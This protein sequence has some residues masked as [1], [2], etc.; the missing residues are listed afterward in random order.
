[1]SDRKETNTERVCVHCGDPCGS[2]SIEVD[3]KPFCCAG[4]KTVYF[5]LHDHDLQQYYQLEQQPGLKPRLEAYANRFAYLDDPAV[6][7]KLLDF[8]DGRT[9]RVRL[10]IPQ[11]HCS[12][13]IWLLENLYILDK[14]IRSSRVDFPNKRVAV[15]FSREE[16]S[17]RRL[18]EL[19][20]SLGYEP[21]I[22]LADLDSKPVDGAVRGLYARLAVAGFCFGNVMLLSFP[23]YLGLDDT[24]HRL[25]GNWFNYLNAL[26][27]T[28][29]IF[30]SASGYFVSAWRGLRKRFVNMDLPI[31]LGIAVL[32]IRSLYDI[33]IL[34]QAGYM[35]S[36][37]G[38]VF[39]LLIGRLYQ[40]KT[41]SA[42]AFDR[43]YRS[44]L[45]IA[46]LRKQDN[47][48]ATVPINHLSP[49]DRIIIRNLELIPADS[50]LISGEGRL[51]YSFV[52]GES[53]PVSVTCG[54]RVY[55]GG[56]QVGAALELEVVKQPSQSYLMQLW[57][58]SEDSAA[59]TVQTDLATL[60]DKASRVFTPAVLAVALGALIYWLFFDPARAMNAATA[61][62]IIACPCA[63]ALSSPFALG[64]AMRL[65]GRKHFYVKDAGVIERLARVS[66]VVFDK[67]GTIT[68]GGAGELRFVGDPLS[69]TQQAAVASLVRQSTYPLSLDDRPE[70]RVY[71]AIDNHSLGYFRLANRYRTGLPEVLARLRAGFRLGLLTGDND[72]ERPR[73]SEL[74][75][76]TAH[77]LFR[78]TPF[79]KLEYV[80]SLT[81]TGERVLMVGDGL[82]DAGA[83]RAASVGLSVAEKKTSFSPACDGII[84][85]DSFA[86]LPALLTLARRSVTVIKAS[87]AISLL[88]NVAGLAFAVQG[89][90]SP[91]IAAILMPI[92]SV[93]VV[94]FASLATTLAAKRTG[95]A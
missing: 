59:R 38:L 76:P 73:L 48:E 41:Y 52:T 83:L 77:L 61:V 34:S 75:G 82:N 13:C 15:T 14:G 70:T 9:A 68:Q 53:E 29:V 81:N 3:G 31:S 22:R 2:G 11:I 1:M 50:V 30:Y 74:F 67:T 17:L 32:F 37:C 26:L 89:I 20:T 91:V 19:M 35:D 54:D 6:R 42:M 84:D 62:L 7:D 40:Q 86:L 92:S 94:L 90:V 63:L 79:Q 56:R 27:A 95:V 21:D 85:A 39:F 45:P 51:D 78:Q 24:L 33:F 10:S 71:V 93:T 72:S 65:M 57:T 25:L 12:S 4:C 18:V 69:D 87:F 80:R 49:G 8:D 88:Y 60:A 47:T 55:A 5:L 43:D 28:P 64:T 44:Y 36:M 16:L 58:Q 23:E 46:V 66:S